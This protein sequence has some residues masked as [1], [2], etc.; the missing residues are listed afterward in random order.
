M[1]ALVRAFRQYGGVVVGC[2]AAP[3]V[4]MNGHLPAEVTR[5]LTSDTSY[6]LGWLLLGI[7]LLLHETR[8]YK[9]GGRILL[10]TAADRAD[11]AAAQH[12]AEAE[13]KKKTK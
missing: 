13:E 2:V 12:T 4:V 5:Y 8:P 1:A 10:A 7:A 9:R 3:L 6:W 11:A